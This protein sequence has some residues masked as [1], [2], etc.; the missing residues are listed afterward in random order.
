MLVYHTLPIMYLFRVILKTNEKTASEGKVQEKAQVT[1][2]AVKQV[3]HK[4]KM[5]SPCVLIKS[6]SAVSKESKII[7]E[8][9]VPQGRCL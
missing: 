9:S 2:P 7:K 4:P 5:S 3:K 6:L 8:P 1:L